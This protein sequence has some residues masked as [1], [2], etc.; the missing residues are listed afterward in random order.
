MPGCCPKFPAVNNFDP[1]VALRKKIK[2]LERKSKTETPEQD[3]NDKP[4]D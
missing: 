3:K 1:S 2:R 4:S